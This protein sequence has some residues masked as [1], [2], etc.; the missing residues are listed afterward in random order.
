MR[1]L[2]KLTGS[3]AVVA[4]ALRNHVSSLALRADADC[5]NASRAAGS[6]GDKAGKKEYANRRSHKESRVRPFVLQSAQ[7]FQLIRQ[8]GLD[9]RGAGGSSWYSYRK[10]V[11]G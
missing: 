9:G 1:S 6:P 4:G 10:G 5:R 8:R 2:K 3:G 7:A 11:C